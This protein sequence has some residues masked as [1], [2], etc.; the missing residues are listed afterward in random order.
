MLLHGNQREYG[1]MLRTVTN[2]FPSQVE[3]LQNIIPL[4][5][6]LAR[7]GHDLSRQ[8]LESRR[9][10]CSIHSEQTKALTIVQAKGHTLDGFDR[11]TIPIVSLLELAHSDD[12]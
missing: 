1:V 11:L 6:N 5:L 2:Q 8:T 7:S 12:I 3:L 4:H 10:A 9:L